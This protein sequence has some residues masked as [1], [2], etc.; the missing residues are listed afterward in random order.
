MM[1]FDERRCIG[2]IM[3]RGPTGLEAFNAADESLG[4]FQTETDAA[5]AVWRYARGQRGGT[6]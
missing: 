1:V 4:L 3:R 2:Q 5:A 6:P